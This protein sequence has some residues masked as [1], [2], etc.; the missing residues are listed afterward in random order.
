MVKQFIITFYGNIRTA[1]LLL[2][3]VLII[4]CGT[5]AN[6]VYFQEATHN[7]QLSP[8]KVEYIR[9]QPT[10]QI[11]I[12]VNSRDPQVASM[13]NLPYYGKRLA[14]L[15]S[16]SG[17]GGNMN[18]NSQ[19][20]SGYTVDSQGNIDFP[21]LGNI[22]LAGLTREEAEDH[23]K[24]L[25]IESR[26]IKDPVVIV[27]FMNLG[28]SVLGEVSRPGRYKIDRDR[29]TIFD[30]LSLAGDLTINGQRENLALVRHEGEQDIL[31]RLDLLDIE[32]IYAS[33]AFYVQQGDVIYVTP[34]EKRQRESTI[35]GNNVRSTSFW[36]SVSSLVTS[37]TTL[38][39][40]VII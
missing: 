2:G 12:V 16:L 33:P 37:I 19:S 24:S 17:S 6:I 5:P 27:E 29:F 10:D 1:M 36:L 25:L 22:H 18:A 9:L 28:F 3:V 7:S 34:N 31:Y 23:I 38:L 30:A 4:S 32:H 14:E 39:V 15:Q 21:V 8:L 11:S 13:F 20:I 26:Q 35:N 40:S